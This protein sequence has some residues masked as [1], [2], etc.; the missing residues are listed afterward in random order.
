ML[1]NPSETPSIQALSGT[2]CCG[3]LCPPPWPWGCDD[4]AK[5][6][7]DLVGRVP[8]VQMNASGHQRDAAVAD[9]ERED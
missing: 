4:R 9:G 8:L 3:G 6:V 1:F 2:Q 7:H 5:E